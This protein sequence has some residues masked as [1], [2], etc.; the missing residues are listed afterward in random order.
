M[1]ASN[2]PVGSEVSPNGVLHIKKEMVDSQSFAE[3]S[4]SNS[5]MYSPTTTVMHD[6][7]S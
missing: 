2:S 4:P 1:M 5:E 3:C 6:S 7:V